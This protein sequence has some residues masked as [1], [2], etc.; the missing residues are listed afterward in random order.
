MYMTGKQFH[1]LRFPVP[2]CLVSI[3]D[4][5]ESAWWRQILSPVTSIKID[6]LL[7]SLLLLPFNHKLCILNMMCPS[8]SKA[9][10]ICAKLP[11]HQKL[12]RHTH[13]KVKFTCTLETPNT[14]ADV[15]M[16]HC[17]LFTNAFTVFT[18]G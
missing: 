9:R 11:V 12:C 2:S 14:Y 16:A 5:Q 6:F 3:Q 18:P 8:F 4:L 1:L 17:L 10:D 7:P 13:W 15:C